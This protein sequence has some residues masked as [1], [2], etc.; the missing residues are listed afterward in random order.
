MKVA[1][2]SSDTSEIELI[3]KT[4]TISD[5]KQAE[6]D[7]YTYYYFTLEQNTEIVFMSSIENSNLQPFMMTA[8]TNVTIKYYNSQIEEGIGI[9]KEISLK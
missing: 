7:G 4:G 6:I 2:S 8:G 3:E 1:D 5:V 9:V